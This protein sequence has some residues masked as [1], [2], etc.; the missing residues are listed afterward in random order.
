ML[1]YVN[2]KGKV[3]EFDGKKYFTNSLSLR[4]YNWDYDTE[5]N[6]IKN[7]NK[8]APT[9]KKMEISV[10][11]SE[12]EQNIKN[13]NSI[14]EI[15]EDDVLSKIPGKLYIGDYYFKCFVI[16]SEKQNIYPQNILNLDL[17]LVSDTNCWTKESTFEFDIDTN[18]SGHGYVYGYPY[19]YA[20]TGIKSFLNDTF[21]DCDFRLRIFGPATNPLIYIGDNIYKVNY[22]VNPREYLEINS[23]QKT[24][25]LVQIDGTHVSVLNYRDRDNYIFQ[26]IVPGMNYISWSNGFSFEI[27]VFD[28]RS[29]PPWI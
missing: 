26:K 3:I 2:N 10:K 9:T 18:L 7:F 25:D 17:T 14:F 19:R 24:L 12:N 29:E 1:K 22:S 6:K 28:E 15:F 5:Y 8:N 23:F 20:S 21:S 4:D 27:T 11:L 13:F 16:A